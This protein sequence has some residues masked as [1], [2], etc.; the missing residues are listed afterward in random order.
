MKLM[1][2]YNEIPNPLE[3]PEVI[4]KIYKAYVNKH[5]Y[6]NDFYTSLLMTIDKDPNSEYNKE[7]ANEFY[8]LMFNKWKESVISTTEEECQKIGYDASYKK[9]QNY[10]KT[11]P[12]IHTEQ[13]AH[14][15]LLSHYQ[16]KELDY[17][18]HKYNWENFGDGKNWFHVNSALLSSYRNVP[19]E[20]EHRLYLDPNVSETFK[21]LTEFVKK[22]D[23][24]NL[25]YYFKYDV[26]S[27]RSD[28]VV[29]YSDM[30]NLLSYVQ[31]LKEIKTENPDLIS[32]FKEPPILTGKIDNWIGYG[33]EPTIKDTDGKGSY[34]TIRADIIDEAISKNIDE[35]LKENANA[36]VMYEDQKIDLNEYLLLSAIKNVG[37]DLR[38]KYNRQV[39]LDRA[40]DFNQGKLYQ[41]NETRDKLGYQPSDINDEKIYEELYDAKIAKPIVSDVVNGTSKFQDYKSTKIT[42]K[43]DAVLTKEHIRQAI[44]QF[45][46]SVAQTEPD[47]RIK[48]MR[49]IS[50][51]SALKGIDSDNFVFDVV[52]LDKMKQADQEDKEMIKK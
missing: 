49:D 20:V 37:Y 18:M 51:L 30:N 26:I 9:L 4:K 23:K 47:F 10:L 46:Y 34:N 48:V 6:D 14:K 27:Q 45:T 50:E 17:A 22:C 39:M 8:S 36:K 11:I 13:E 15:I 40:M 28:P 33:V 16:D 35:W 52:T 2:L 21:L 44:D 32:K 24:Y 25:P 42:D 5:S 38:E 29:I 43:K 41:E 1:D 7:D 3:D 12:D 31:I 19:G